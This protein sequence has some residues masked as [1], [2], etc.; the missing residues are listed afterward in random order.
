M[1]RNRTS[2]SN[3][4]RGL[5]E[6]LLALVWECATDEQ[7]GSWLRVPLEH[8]AAQSGSSRDSSSY[9]A[10]CLALL[11]AGAD[12]FVRREPVLDR[13]PLLAAAQ[14]GNGAVVS[15]L[16]ENGS[17][18]D[19]EDWETTSSVFREVIFAAGSSSRALLAGDTA[20]I[21]DGRRTPLHFAAA[22]GHA[23]MVR[24]LVGAGADVDVEDGDGCTP[25]HLAVFRG[26]E[27]V[28]AVLVEAGARVDTSDS[29]GESPV[30]TASAHGSL[31]MVR[32]ILRGSP[33]KTLLS[34]TDN[35][36]MSPLHRAALGGHCEV[37]NELLRH[38]SSLHSLAANART[39]LHAVSCGV[40]RWFFPQR[41][42]SMS[43][44]AQEPLRVLYSFCCRCLHHAR[45]R[46]LVFPVY[47]RAT[48]RTQ[49]SSWRFCLCFP[50][51][52][53]YLFV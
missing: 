26:Y 33:D 11:E 7:L 44:G 12:A 10:L 28:V 31:G 35:L 27:S 2:N 18:P 14:A 32:A 22:G 49:R 51:M 8:A 16:L 47:P 52:I 41:H 50:F 53:L 15:A 39:A 48:G 17:A 25:L 40:P 29:E 4:L 46:W 23:S 5:G 37:M 1:S 45:G 20:I 43:S 42:Y 34:P 36:E 38:G 24:A 6:Q 30:H 19:G 3:P 21:S 9:E 13:S